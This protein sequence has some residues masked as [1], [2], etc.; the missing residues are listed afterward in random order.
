MHRHNAV[1]AGDVLSPTAGSGRI[2]DV[3]GK[4]RLSRTVAMIWPY[5]D[6]GRMVGEDVWEYDDTD[7]DFIKLDAADVLTT[8][9]AATLVDQFIQPLPSVPT[10]SC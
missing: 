10:R 3:V 2:G 8:K 5:D 7:R 6:R 4:V 9:Q 1:L